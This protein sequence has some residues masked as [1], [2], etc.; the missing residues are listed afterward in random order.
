[1]PG[2]KR[3]ET[4]VFPVIIPVPNNVPDAAKNTT[5]LPVGELPATERV[6]LAIVVPPV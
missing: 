2:F 1:L 3:P 4:G 6:P 5:P